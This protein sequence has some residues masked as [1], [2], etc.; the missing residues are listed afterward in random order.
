M[1]RLFVTLKNKLRLIVLCILGM[2]GFD[3]NSP[4]EYDFFVAV[5]T[6]EILLQQN[7]MPLHKHVLPCKSDICLIQPIADWRW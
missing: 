7:D 4:Q 6:A 3:L 5:Y 1:G 2:S